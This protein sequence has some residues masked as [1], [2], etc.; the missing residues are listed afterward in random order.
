MDNKKEYY[1]DAFTSY[2]KEN[3]KAEGTI[4]IYIDNLKLFIKYYIQTYGEEFIPEKVITMDLKDYRTYQINRGNK[5]NTINNRMAA[6][7]EYFLFLELKGII[8]KSPARTIKKIKINNTS[9]INKTF[10]D[11]EFKTIKRAVYKEGN[12]MDA[13][14]FETLS[15]CGL[16]ISELINLK[17]DDI[18]CAERSGNLRIIGKGLKERNVPLHL[19]VRKTF[20][21][22]LPT[23]N[24][25]GVNLPYIL[26]NEKGTMFT[27]SGVYKRLL[28]YENI[29]GVEIHPHKF[30]SFFASYI[31]KSNSISVCQYLLGHD[32]IATTQK[33]LSLEQV[34]IK[35]AI[36]SL[37]NL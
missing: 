4:K 3:D 20:E 16:R 31:L 11:K 6:A 12:A 27:R 8:E 9:P 26:I 35:N 14:I 28:K 21:N 13:F 10:T 1:I 2:L 23:R 30:R 17:M 34:D 24:K 29:T 19:D 15:K 25:K 5:A 7:K 36:E 37:T 32:S 18:T 22:Y 33:Y